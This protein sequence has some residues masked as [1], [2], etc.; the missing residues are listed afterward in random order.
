MESLAVRRVSVWL[1]SPLPDRGAYAHGLE[2]ATRFQ[3]PLCPFVAKCRQWAARSQSSVVS[4]AG[5]QQSDVA[6]EAPATALYSS[7][8]PFGRGN[9][10]GWIPPA[11]PKGIE[12]IDESLDAA[13]LCVFGHG[14][15]ASVKEELLRRS[16]RNQRSSTLLCPDYWQPLTRVLVLFDHRDPGNY[17]RSAAVEVC[18]RFEVRP[19][20]LTVA[21]SE[22]GARE[23]Q[24]LAEQAMCECDCL[25]DF[26]YVVGEDLRNAVASVAR[27]RR[28]SHVFVEKRY[29]AS[30]WHWPWRSTVERLLALSSFVAVL[31]LPGELPPSGFQSSGGAEDPEA[32]RKAVPH[33]AP[34]F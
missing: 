26:D 16:L 7:G 28:C 17:F 21:A 14:L 24:L 6:V 19:I 18:R 20:I 13:S 5:A 2:W 8:Q 23:R 32:R 25:A 29:A 31:S 4:G 27:W 30:W 9:I 15:P 11:P 1:D 34:P 22:S 33:D 3:L 10:H 12:G